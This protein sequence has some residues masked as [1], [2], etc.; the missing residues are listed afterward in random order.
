MTA[1]RRVACPMLLCS[2]AVTGCSHVRLPCY[3]ASL[4]P[5]RG[6]G[7]SLLPLLSAPR[8]AV[9]RLSYYAARLR[10][11][12][13]PAC[14]SFIAAQLSSHASCSR[15]L[16]LTDGT[17]AIA[18]R[19]HSSFSMLPRN[20]APSMALADSVSAAST[21]SLYC[22]SSTK[23]VAPATALRRQLPLYCP[24]LS[25]F[26]LQPC[27]IFYSVW[28]ALDRTGRQPAPLLSRSPASHKLR[29]C[30]HSIFGTPATAPRHQ[31]CFSPSRAS[32]PH[33]S[34]LAGCDRALLLSLLRA[35]DCTAATTCLCCHAA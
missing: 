26:G 13:T 35:R 28:H 34:S 31:S 15:A 11:L 25:P 3:V 16:I 8:A 6:V 1:P 12:A 5:H 10:P 33:S 4:R 24:R 27:A 18:L 14:P 22:L 32:L 17:P 21:S 20:S 29:H 7:P 23:G 19:C 30:A 9:V 2:S